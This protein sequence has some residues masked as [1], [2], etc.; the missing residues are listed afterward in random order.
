MKS[1][2]G[3]QTFPIISKRQA[4]GLIFIFKL[5][6]DISS[7]ILPAATTQLRLGRT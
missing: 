1:D 4:S 7:S 5:D 2:S 3:K 6:K